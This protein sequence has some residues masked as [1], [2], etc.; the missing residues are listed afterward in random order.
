[1]ASTPKFSLEAFLRL[2][3]EKPESVYVTKGALETAAAELW[4]QTK[5]ECVE[6]IASFNA[7][8]CE[9]Q[10]SRRWDNVS[11]ATGVECYCDAY[12][13][14]QGGLRVYVSFGVGVNQRW[15]VEIKSLKKSDR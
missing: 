5:K 15:K 3:R 8:E 1:M 12:V 9:F 14:V 10:N 11:D 4:L 2:C 6:F 7:S 13:F